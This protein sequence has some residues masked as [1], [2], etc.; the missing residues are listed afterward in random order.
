MR[1]GIIASP[2]WLQGDLRGLPL[3]GRPFRFLGYQESSQ[4]CKPL[5]TGPSQ[6]LKPRGLF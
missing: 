6:P 5:F 4:E 1:Y 2:W 3:Q